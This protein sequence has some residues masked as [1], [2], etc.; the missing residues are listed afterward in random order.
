[1]EEELPTPKQAKTI[2]AFMKASKLCEGVTGTKDGLTNRSICIK[3]KMEKIISEIDDSE[4]E[5]IYA[6]IKKKIG[7]PTPLP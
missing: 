6:E 2:Y 7:E 4:L 3:E 5:K 1:M